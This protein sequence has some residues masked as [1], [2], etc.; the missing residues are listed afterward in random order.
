MGSR[1]SIEGFVIADNHVLLECSH[2]GILG[3][4]EVASIARTVGSEHLATH[5][6]THQKYRSH[7]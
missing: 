6:C 1:V 4:S 7:E 2:C 3:I 5:G